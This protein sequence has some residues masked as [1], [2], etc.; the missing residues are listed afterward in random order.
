VNAVL[1]HVKPACLAEHAYTLEARRAAVKV[2]QNENPF[3]L[4]EP[5]K[6]RVLEQ[7]MRREWSRYPD[8]DPSE[9]RARLAAFA[10]WRADGVLVGNG[11]NEL[12]QAL[13]LTTVGAGTPVVIPEPSF[14]LYALMTRLLG[15]TCVPAQ[16]A[17]SSSTTRPRCRRPAAPAGLRSRSCARRT[18][19]RAAA[20]RA[21]PCGRCF[22]R[23]TGSWRGRG[24]PRVLGGLG[25]AVAPGVRAPDRAAHVL[26]GHGPGRPAHRLP[27]GRAGLGARDRQGAPALQPQLLLAAQ[28]AG[29][30]RR[31][32]GAARQRRAA[33]L[34][35]RARVRC[36]AGAAGRAPVP[37]AGQLHPVELR[38]GAPREVFERCTP[39]ACWCATCPRPRAWVAACA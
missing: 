5:A 6:R 1:K 36:A 10:G 3:D 20:C 17:P 38:A 27:A 4:P 11:S 30:A 24:L 22:A 16:L 33:A 21:R 9:L 25:P 32:R 28:R 23:A 8:F 13:L 31:G 18:T 14:A 12:I 37:V 34:G 35:T 19:R 29:G 15:G 7:A 26:Q 2:N 39:G